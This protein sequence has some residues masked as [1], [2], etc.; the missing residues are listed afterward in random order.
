M[1]DR[2]PR[3][4]PSS[5]GCAGI[6][7]LR[8]EPARALHARAPLSLALSAVVED[9]GGALAYW[10]LEHPAGKPDFH[11]A[12][13][14]D[15]S[16]ICGVHPDQHLVIIGVA[17]DIHVPGNSGD[18]TK[19]MHIPIEHF[20]AVVAARTAGVPGHENVVVQRHVQ[21]VEA[22]R[23]GIENLAL[24]IRGDLVN[25]NEAGIA[26]ERE[27]ISIKRNVGLAFA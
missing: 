8:Y 16:R 23:G 3:Q 13:V 7:V 17:S 4:A 1:N 27:M 9:L 14:A 2:S 21:P 20:D 25:K 22:V 19:E 6:E 12:V 18:L 26:G 10:A 24:R 11:D 15:R 5:G